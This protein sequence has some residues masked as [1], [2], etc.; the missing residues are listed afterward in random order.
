MEV[1]QLG[2]FWDREKLITLTITI[3]G[4]LATLLVGFWDLINVI[5]SDHINWMIKYQLSH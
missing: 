1:A 4:S 5:Q 2:S 3:S